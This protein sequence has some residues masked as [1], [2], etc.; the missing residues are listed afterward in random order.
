[1]SKPALKASQEG[2]KQAQEAFTQRRFT[3][4]SLAHHLGCNRSV[5]GKFFNGESIWEKYFTSI[6]QE[7][8]IE[9]QKVVSGYVPPLVQEVRSKVRELIQEWCGSMRILDMT[10]PIKLSQIYTHVNILEKLT[11]TRRKTIEELLKEC[12][13]EDFDRFG[14][15]KVVEEK[16]PGVDAV[17]KYKKLIVLGKPGAGKTTFLKYLAIQCN[18]GNFQSNLVPIFIPLKYFAEASDKPSLFEYI[19]QQYSGCDVTAEQFDYLFKHGLALILL[20]G[21]DEVS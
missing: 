14:L 8:G 16:V 1:M 5:I 10:Q 12:E 11:A 19:K 18:Q 7:L 4:E 15:G 13:Y 9:W 21:L 2:V 17:N 3:Q 20:D 6:C